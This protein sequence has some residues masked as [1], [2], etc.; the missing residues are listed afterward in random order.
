[1]LNIDRVGMRNLNKALSEQDE[2]GSF[3][4]CSVGSERCKQPPIK[5]HAVPR[6]A[7]KL[8][9]QS[10]K[11]YATNAN[12]P[13]NPL[14]FYNQDPLSERSIEQFSVG[15]WACGHHDQIFNPIDS[16]NI[17]LHLKSNLFLII[18]RIT[19][20]AT[21][22]A[23]RTVGRIAIPML[24]PAVPTPKGISEDGAEELRQ[25]AFNA[26]PA[27]ARLFSIKAAMDRFWRNKDY[28]RLDYRVITWKTKPV[29][30]GAGI[31]WNDG[32]PGRLTWSGNTA[33]LPGWLI[34]LPQK[35]G[36]AIITACPKGFSKY[37]NEINGIT[38][39]KGIEQPILTMIGPVALIL[40]F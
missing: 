35:Y 19:L 10:N 39:E 3:D 12:P 24:D 32:P 1:M 4:R 5:A 29:M 7:L 33:C 28:H 37:A 25:F 38:E 6:S 34:I 40:R 16:N 27:V 14:A 31:I 22:L 20:R 15:K 26:T 9:A 18:Y 30:A 21:Q 36:Q 17:D 8:I 2:A 11:V 13:Q 23:L